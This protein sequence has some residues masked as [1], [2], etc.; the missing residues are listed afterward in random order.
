MIVNPF[1]FGNR[2]SLADHKYIA[3]AYMYFGAITG[4]TLIGIAFQ[5]VFIK[6]RSDYGDNALNDGAAR[7]SSLLSPVEVPKSKPNKD[8]RS[9][10]GNRSNKDNTD[11]EN[12]GMEIM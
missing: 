12:S 2:A 3:T 10:R 11:V 8:R 5:N 6:R 4:L 9:I 1:P 7:R